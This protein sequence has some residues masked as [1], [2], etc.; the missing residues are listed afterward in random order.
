MYRA[1]LCWP[2]TAR[3]R[4]SRRRC[5]VTSNLRASPNCLTRKSTGKSTSGFRRT[6]RRLLVPLCAH[7]WCTELVA[8][9]TSFL[10]KYL[11]SSMLWSS[12]LHPR[13]QTCVLHPDKLR[14]LRHVHQSLQ[15]PSMAVQ[16]VQVGYRWDTGATVP[17]GF[18]KHGTEAI[19]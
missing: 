11:S 13:L 3:A 15:H 7:H 18:E 9:S 2:T 19:I 1:A 10:W 16:L 4:K 8:T 6:A 17:L 12:T 5:T 14:S